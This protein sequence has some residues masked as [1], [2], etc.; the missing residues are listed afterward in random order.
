MATF[1][2]QLDQIQ[3]LRFAQSQADQKA[4]ST[5][6]AIQ[7]KMTGGSQSGVIAFAEFAGSAAA[8]SVWSKT[9]CRRVT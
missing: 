2:E 9:F 3:K 5:K 6:L 4:Y 8:G 7:K 1:Q